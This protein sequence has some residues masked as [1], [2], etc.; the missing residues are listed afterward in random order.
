[1][2]EALDDYA[3]QLLGS[4]IA[5]AA[6]V[7]VADS[8]RTL[9]EASYGAP[10]DALWPIASIGKGFAAVIA[11]QLADEGAIRL[12]DPITSALPWFAVR[13]GDHGI[14]WHHLLTHSSGIVASS[15]LAPASG[16]DAIAL[17]DTA[18]GFE[19]GGHRH[20]S[21]AG[22]RVIGVALEA[23]TGRSYGELV[24]RRVL[25]RLGLRAAAPTTTHALRPR[26]PPGA[27]PPFDDRPWLPEHGLVPAPWVEAAEADGCSCCTAAELVEFARALWRADPVLLSPAGHAA[28]REPHPPDEPPAY[29]YGL[30]LDARG[31]GHGGDM[32]GHVSH[33]RVDVDA[34]LAVAAFAS[35]LG[36]AR[37]L[38][39]AA[40][41][42]AAGSAPAALEPLD[43]PPAL[44]DDGSGGA[45]QRRCVGRFRCHNPW[46]P[47][48]AVAARAGALVLGTD[49]LD[50][51]ERLPLTPA[52]AA[53]FRVGEPAWT[54]ERLC[55]DTLVDGV[56]QRA[57][58]SGTPY[59]RAYPAG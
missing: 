16:F 58:L 13:G 19:P 32:L 35:G 31:F 27:A 40:L 20:Y 54:P 21:N 42:I 49:W 47:T 6:A 34:G 12:G 23:V 18:L 7:V 26:V 45:A 52:G 3:A 2:R 39:E 53:G 5:N 56:F 1:M 25:D 15:D 22:Y 51:S 38:G 29:G 9:C 24:Q 11:L 57:L 8:D 41:A 14:T 46:L 4:G 48:F 50:G 30:E 44:A 10:R 28:M 43:T 37:S 55:F 17:R 33:M 59:Y 36:G